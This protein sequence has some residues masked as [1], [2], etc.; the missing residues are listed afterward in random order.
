[1]H[2]TIAPERVTLDSVPAALDPSLTLNEWAADL[3]RLHAFAL[4]GAQAAGVDANYLA[5]LGRRLFQRVF[6]G[7]VLTAYRHALARGPFTLGLSVSDPLA[8]LPWELLYD[9]DQRFYLGA[10]GRVTLYRRREGALAPAPSPAS[11]TRLLLVFAPPGD[12]PVYAPS[13]IVALAEEGLRLALAEGQIVLD[14]EPSGTVAALNDRLN[15]PTTRPHLVH[16]VGHGNVKDG[17]GVLGFAGEDGDHHP[18]GGVRLRELF[19]GK[20]VQG[21]LL[22]ACHSGQVTGA[23]DPLAMVAQAILQAGVPAVVAQQFAARVDTTHRFFARLYTALANGDP[24]ERAAAF[25][26]HALWVE[27]PPGD[28]NPLGFAVPVCYLVAETGPCLGPAPESPPPSPPEPPGLAEVES[29]PHTFTGREQDVRRVEAAWRQRPLVALC[30]GGGVGKTALAAHLARANRWRFPGGVFWAS[31]RGRKGFAVDHVA[32]AVLRGLGVELAGV[33]DLPAEARR[34][35]AGRTCL[36]V[37]DNFEAIPSP[38]RRPIYEWL[39]SLPQ[40][41]LALLTSRERLRVRGLRTLSLAPLDAAA[42]WALFAELL[43]DVRGRAEVSGEELPAVADILALLGGWPLALEIVAALSADASLA[44]V[45]ADLRS[46]R[47]EALAAEIE[48]EEASIVRSLGASYE[49]LAEGVRT[50]FRRLG[51]LWGDFGSD[52][53]AVVGQVED[54]A[55]LARGLRALVKR[56]LL[57]QP[58]PAF[59]RWQMHGTLALF[60]R[61]RLRAVEGEGAVRATRLHAADYFRD[62]ARQFGTA[63]DTAEATRQARKLADEQLNGWVLPRLPKEMQS[64][65]ASLS[66]AEKEDLAISFAVAQARVALETERANIGAAIQWAAE[67]GEH[68]LAWELV[69]AVYAWLDQAG[70]WR[71]A[72]EYK[73]LALAAARKAGD[74]RAVAVWA[75]N[76]A[77]TL[78]SLGEKAEAEA[79]YA[80]AERVLA[81]SEHQREMAAV[82]HQRGILAQSR[83]DYDAAL[84]HHR[85]SLEIFEQLGDRAGVASSLNAIGLVLQERGDYDKALDYYQR[86]LQEADAIGDRQQIATVLHAIGLVHRHLGDYD[87]ALEHH[88]RSLE[89]KEQL[90]NRAGVAKSLNAIGIVLQQRG[91]YDKALDYYQR[92]LQE[93]E[94]IGDRQQIATVLHAIGMVHQ[95]RGDYPAALEH[96]RCSLEID[97]QLGNRAGVA[98]SLHQIGMVHQ[99]QGDYPA[100]LGH[101]RRSLETFEQLGDRVGVAYSLGQIGNVHQARGEWGQA[102]KTHQQVQAISEEM[103]DRPSVAIALHQIGMVHQARGDYA[104]ALEH[105][106]RSLEIREHLGDRAGV[107]SSLGQ[108]GQ[109]AQ[110]Q[111]DY[112]TA[113]RLWAQALATFEALGMPERNIVLG[114]F[115]GLREELGAERFEAVL[116]EVG[117][118]YDNESGG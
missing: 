11:P 66:R 24:L 27:T 95:R 17:V 28:D 105:Y 22:T 7:D 13:E 78:G 67:A 18:L 12:L 44:D 94:A 43:T 111:E 14:Y 107:A 84:E 1:M 104:A 62:Y 96:Y 20:G 34:Q 75:H 30:G 25:G 42:A 53:A 72:V 99:A 73:R 60:A 6:V 56:S 79:L 71:E 49:R 23:A 57:E 16:F 48:E 29:V 89:M 47:A 41:T 5:D 9:P 92:S 112:V 115:T 90:G 114:W 117:L 55:V 10:A 15:D 52:A 97:E 45:L 93:A 68:G 35:L 38:N 81:A 116:R 108:I 102:L 101:Y 113:V 65:Y 87:V 19:A 21:V 40:G 61:S 50:L 36:V 118:E 86:S 33:R 54:G 98:R 85:R 106:R 80:E 110:L 83:G 109:V 69:D 37:V 58:H 51:A 103:G 70:Y 32:E 39:R 82:L 88:H 31:A 3:A 64:Q 77:L 2:L 91:D 26:R 4:T 46:D 8:A 63:M 74:E 59:P 76:L 100:A